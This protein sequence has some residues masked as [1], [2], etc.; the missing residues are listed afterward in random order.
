MMMLRL[1]VPRQRPMAGSFDGLAAESA[2]S[3]VSLLS[4]SRV[5]S[6][7][8]KQGFSSAERC[9]KPSPSLSIRMSGRS[10]P[11]LLA[12]NFTSILLVSRKGLSMTNHRKNNK[13]C[14]Q[15]THYRSHTVIQFAKQ[16]C[17]FPGK[18]FMPVMHSKQI[19]SL[20]QQKTGQ[21]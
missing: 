16:L 2:N 15:T 4:P 14:K 18:I 12:Q 5:I 20:R 17:N 1:W 19:L 13:K 3:N 9:S 8:R 7:I 6:S 10:F 11:L 21:V